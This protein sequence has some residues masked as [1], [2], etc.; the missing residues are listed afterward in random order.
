MR[1]NEKEFYGLLIILNFFLINVFAVSD[2]LVFYVFFEA[3]VMPMFILIG[4]W[5]SRERK[6]FATYQFFVYTVIGSVFMLFAVFLLYSHFGTT[7]IRVLRE[8]TVSSSRQL[9]F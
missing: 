3:I 4:V 1:Y 5:G 9:F 6:I 7:D 8:L 2:L